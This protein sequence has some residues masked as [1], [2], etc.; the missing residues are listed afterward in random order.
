[1]NRDTHCN[2]NFLYQL[3]LAATD[4][5]TSYDGRTVR[6]CDETIRSMVPVGT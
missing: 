6:K 5:R 3:V 1:M 4:G 2:F